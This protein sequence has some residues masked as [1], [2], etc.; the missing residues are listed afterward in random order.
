M[1]L[2]ATGAAEQIEVL[3]GERDR[4]AALA[5]DTI[6]ELEAMTSENIHLSSGA[7]V[8]E[9]ERQSFK[10]ALAKLTGALQA[11]THALYTQRAC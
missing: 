8:H 3:E 1:T 4:L 7:V 10:R 9:E 11:G 5:D 2:R 6:A